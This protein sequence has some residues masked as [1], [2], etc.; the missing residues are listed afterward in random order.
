M[1]NL[2]DGQ[3]VG[4]ILEFGRLALKFVGTRPVEEFLADEIRV[5][6]TTYVVQ[7]VGEAASHLSAELRASL[8]DIPWPRIVGMRNRLVHGY[9]GI[10]YSIVWRVTVEEMPRLMARLEPFAG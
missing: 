6:A 4:D 7:V 10:D 5:Y 1:T 9:G 2:D 8:D 3:L